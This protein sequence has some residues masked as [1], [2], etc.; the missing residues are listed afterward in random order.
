MV[1]ECLKLLRGLKM[2]THEL[3][4]I[5]VSPSIMERMPITTSQLPCLCT[6]QNSEMPVVA[7]DVGMAFT[8]PRGVLYT[9]SQCQISN[10]A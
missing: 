2:C 1:E 5:W 8:N 10:V 7:M 3:S 9:L 4:D 6:R